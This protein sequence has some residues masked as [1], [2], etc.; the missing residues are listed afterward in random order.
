MLHAYRITF[1]SWHRTNRRMERHLAWSTGRSSWSALRHWWQA[2]RQYQPLVE[3]EDIT[4]D[5]RG[6][7][8]VQY[9]TT[10][11]YACPLA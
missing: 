3:V 10:W 11:A 8:Q 7:P 2:Q 6:C 5:H 1:R 9:P 4:P